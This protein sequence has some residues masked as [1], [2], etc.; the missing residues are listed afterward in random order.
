VRLTKRANT[1]VRDATHECT[2]TF[3][4]NMRHVDMLL[5]SPYH[6]IIKG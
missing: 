2:L 6:N 3:G 5:V 4:A 1:V